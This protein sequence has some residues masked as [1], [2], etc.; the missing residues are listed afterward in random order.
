MEQDE[1]GEVPKC[2][3]CALICVGIFRALFGMREYVQI[4]SNYIIL[5]SSCY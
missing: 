4:V 3:M 5:M 1:A 2:L